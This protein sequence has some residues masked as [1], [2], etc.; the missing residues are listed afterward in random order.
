MPGR[1]EALSFNG[2]WE[3]FAAMGWN[4]LRPKAFPKRIS[5]P[6]GAKWAV[7]DKGFF[8]KGELR[9]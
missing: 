3:P 9:D 8:G 4:L 5:A 7:F 6:I 1:R 2:K